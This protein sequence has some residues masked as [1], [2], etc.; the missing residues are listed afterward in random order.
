MKFLSRFIIIIFICLSFFFCVYN[1][2]QAEE[3]K[4]LTA[5]ITKVPQSFFGTW[6]VASKRIDTDAESIFK[7]NSIDIWN[8]SKTFDVIT[9]SNPFNGAK[10]EIILDRVDSNY[11]VFTKQGKYGKKVLTDTVEIKLEG[12]TFVGTDTLK[13]DT[14]SE[15]KITKTQS[16][17]YYLNGEKIAGGNILGE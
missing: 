14:Y 3:T 7:E 6:R 13:I 5:T 8:L 12:D 10:A 4:L 16:A 2:V 17:K 15:G 9:L 11:I 1:N